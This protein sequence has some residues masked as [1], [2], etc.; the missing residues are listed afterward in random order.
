MSNKDSRF[1]MLFK[2]MENVGEIG[3]LKSLLSYLARAK[4]SATKEEIDS[5]FAELSI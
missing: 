1:K 2:T 4:Y 3:L 5:I